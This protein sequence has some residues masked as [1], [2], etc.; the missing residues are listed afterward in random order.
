MS[1]ASFRIAFDKYSSLDVRRCFSKTMVVVIDHHEEKQREMHKTAFWRA[2]QTEGISIC[3]LNNPAKPIPIPGGV[4]KSSE[5]EWR[6]AFEGVNKEK[7]L[8]EP[9]AAAIVVSHL[10]AIHQG[11]EQNPDAGLF[12]ILERDVETNQNSI[13]MFACFMANWWGNWH[14][15]NCQYAGLTFSEWHGP[16]SQAVWK[17]PTLANAEYRPHVRIV[18]CPEQWYVRKTRTRFSFV[19]QAG[20]A[21]AFSAPFARRLL[22]SKVGNVWDLHV[23]DVLSQVKSD[24]EEKHMDTSGMA[25]IVTPPIFTHVP[26]FVDRL[27]GSGRLHSQVVNEAEATSY[28]I[29]LNLGGQWGLSNR[30]QTLILWLRFCSWH[31]FVLGKH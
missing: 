25:G 22:E 30:C 5:V 6:H 3:Y 27:R 9:I 28:Y 13:F 12:I 7:I 4:H 18:D 20:R 14:M 15:R 17:S 23:L 10:R 11:V 1:S 26:L 8:R 31:H 24:W 19:G 21:L 16:Y 29:C 2:C